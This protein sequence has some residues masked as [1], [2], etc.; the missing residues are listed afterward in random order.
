MPLE[1]LRHLLRVLGGAALFLALAVAATHAQPGFGGC[2]PPVPP[3]P[4]D[5]R[6]EF[7]LAADAYFDEVSAF[8]A[9][10]S[11][12]MRTLRED[13]AAELEAEIARLRAFYA[14][15]VEDETAILTE[16]KRLVDREYR[17]VLE[18]YRARQ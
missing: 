1:R 17:E 18:A 15:L 12:R 5:D 6:R 7:E 16:D 14:E 13:Y 11:E 3:P 2:F 4:Y 10:H 9:C 8:Y